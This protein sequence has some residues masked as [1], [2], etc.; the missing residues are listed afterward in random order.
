MKGR[1]TM[2]KNCFV[3]M[4]FGKDK[5]ENKYENEIDKMYAQC[6]KRTRMRYL[7]KKGRVV[8]RSIKMRI[9]K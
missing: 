3:I 2:E 8:L 4:P 5:D 9:F 7:Y 1:D 6:Q